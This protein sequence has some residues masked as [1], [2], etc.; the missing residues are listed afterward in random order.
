MQTSIVRLPNAL[1]LTIQTSFPS[2]NDPAVYTAAG[3]FLS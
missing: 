1:A 2:H 3:I